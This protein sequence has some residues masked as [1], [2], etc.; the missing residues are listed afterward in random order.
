VSWIERAVE[1]QLAEAA[2][3]GDLDIAEPLK[4]KPIPGIDQ[5]Q[6][7]GAWADRFVR[8]E[9]SHD[10][11][12]VAEAA[13]MEARVEFWKASTESALRE[14]VAEA[15]RAIGAANVNLVAADHLD[16]FD[17]DHIVGRWRAIRSGR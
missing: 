5:H 12:Q 2:A 13:A 4:G 15:N 9:L 17:P 1:Q 11:R 14:K 10:R 7:L 6:P 8:R 16:F 3:N